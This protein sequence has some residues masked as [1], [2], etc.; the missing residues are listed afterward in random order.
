MRTLLCYVSDSPA[1][2]VGADWAVTKIVL[3][4][5]VI[6]EDALLCF[7]SLYLVRKFMNPPANKVKVCR[8]EKYKHYT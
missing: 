6:L 2:G 3:I 8:G 4:C 5:V 7:F 1:P